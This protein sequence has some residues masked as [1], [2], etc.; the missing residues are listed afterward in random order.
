ML[1]NLAPRVGAVFRFVFYIPGALAGAA[2]VV[3]WL[4]MLDPTASP[5]A[6]VLHWLGYG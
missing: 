3:V 6:L 5:F 4:F 2:S 1:H